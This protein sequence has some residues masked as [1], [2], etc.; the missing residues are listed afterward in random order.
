MRVFIE[1]NM[2][3]SVNTVWMENSRWLPFLTIQKGMKEQERFKNFINCC[4]VMLQAT[5]TSKNLQ[6]SRWIDE[7][8]I[9]DLE[10]VCFK[11]KLLSKSLAI[12]THNLQ[13]CHCSFFIVSRILSK[14]CLCLWEWGSEMVCFIWNRFETIFM[15]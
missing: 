9:K 7:Y 1:R 14:T 13:K 8:A 4:S 3:I 6:W 2:K 15:S 10:N 11:N 12:K 5:C